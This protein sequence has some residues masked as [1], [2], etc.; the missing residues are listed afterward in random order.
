MEPSSP[1]A[2]PRSAPIVF[3]IK[4]TTAAAAAVTAIRPKLRHRWRRCYQTA[5][6]ERSPEEW[7]SWICPFRPSTMR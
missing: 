7:R 3:V 6:N 1:L 2:V 4:L 5:C